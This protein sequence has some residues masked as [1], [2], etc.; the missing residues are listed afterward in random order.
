M[1]SL[2]KNCPACGHS[3]QAKDIFCQTCGADISHVTPGEPRANAQPA[4]PISS[5]PSPPHN[6]ATS[7]TNLS[8]PT[9]PCPRCGYRNPSFVMLCPHCGTDISEAACAPAQADA[10]TST[11]PVSILHAEI[12]G[13]SR[14]LKPGDVLGREGTVDPDYFLSIG[15]VSRHHVRIDYRKGT[16]WVTTPASVKNTT[17]LDGHELHRGEPTALGASHKLIMSTRCEVKL[18]VSPA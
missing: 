14:K 11:P 16:W 10:E 6:P 4:V 15:T 18:T 3:N 1:S 12:N 9:Q 5:S 17:K 13:L 8:G 2:V 7:L